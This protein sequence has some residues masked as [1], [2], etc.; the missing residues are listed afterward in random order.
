MSQTDCT[1]PRYCRICGDVAVE[2]A[3]EPCGE[4]CLQ[5]PQCGHSVMPSSVE[6][7]TLAEPRRPR[8]TL[9]RKLASE[10]LEVARELCAQQAENWDE[11]RQVTYRAVLVVIDALQARN[12]EE[13]RRLVEVR[14]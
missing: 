13:L 1:T 3:V 7:S 12:P 11:R 6:Y 14:G 10:A 5:C 8:Q 4:P 2:P 9:R